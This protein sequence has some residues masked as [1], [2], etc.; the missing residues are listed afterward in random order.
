VRDLRVD[1]AENTITFHVPGVDTSRSTL[2]AW[3]ASGL[4]DGTGNYLTVQPSQS[5]TAPGGGNATATNGFDLAFV[6]EDRRAVDERIQSDLL[7]KGEI[8]P[9]AAVVDLA[10]LRSRVHRVAGEPTSGPVERVLVSSSNQGD[11]LDSGNAAATFQ[12]PGAG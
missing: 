10:A 12:N 8:G 3:L 2:R 9:A 4:N 11:G 7:A 1:T 6:S 5:A